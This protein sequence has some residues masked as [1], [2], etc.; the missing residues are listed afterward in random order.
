[1]ADEDAIEGGAV[2]V[3]NELTV[4]QGPPASPWSR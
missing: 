4:D 2:S 3:R 1:M